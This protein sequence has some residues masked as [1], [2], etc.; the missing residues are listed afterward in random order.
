MGMLIAPAGK[1]V[2]DKAKAK[3]SAPFSMRLTMSG[4]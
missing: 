1:S 3:S 4:A 2:V